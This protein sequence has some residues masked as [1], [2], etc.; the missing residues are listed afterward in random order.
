M[1]RLFGFGALAT[2]GLVLAAFSPACVTEA[3][4]RGNGTVE[5]RQLP[6]NQVGDCGLCL[7]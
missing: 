5:H 7:W 2:A 3:A 1:A 4:L 6:P